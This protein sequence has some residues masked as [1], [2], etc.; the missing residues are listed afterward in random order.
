MIAVPRVGPGNHCPGFKKTDRP[1]HV[2]LGGIPDDR[3]HTEK[4]EKAGVWAVELGR[5]RGCVNVHRFTNKISQ[6]H[7]LIQR[8][9]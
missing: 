3:G 9:C 1:K 8:R 5:L 4:S 7:I 6:K 2:D